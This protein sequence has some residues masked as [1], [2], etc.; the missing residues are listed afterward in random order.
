MAAKTRK[1]VWK[2]CRIN[3][4]V[5][6]MDENNFV[7]DVKINRA[8]HKE[9]YQE[10]CD[11]ALI[12]NLWIE[13]INPTVMAQSING[14]VRSLLERPG[15]TS[16]Y[17]VFVVRYIIDH[18]MQIRHPAGLRYYADRERIKEAYKQSKLPRIRHS[19]F[20]AEPSED[21]SPKFTVKP[22]KQV[23]FSSVLGGERD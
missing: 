5:I 9:C 23:G 1:C 17:L 15:V 2:C 4:G 12:K 14:V 16:E 6:N 10:K 19:E 11:M 3:G 8:Y 20:I 22:K 13:H 21:D 7:M 18:K